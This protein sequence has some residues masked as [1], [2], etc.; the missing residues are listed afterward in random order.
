MFIATLAIMLIALFLYEKAQS[1][2]IEIAVG[3]FAVALLSLI[4]AI[5]IAPWQIHTV[6]LV[7]VLLASSLSKFD[8]IN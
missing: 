1:V 8:V 6:M 5:V 4:I 7:G 3:C 2:C